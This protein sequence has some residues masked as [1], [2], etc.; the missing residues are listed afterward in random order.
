VHFKF[1]LIKAINVP[2]L[3]KFH[4]TMKL[5]IKV[6]THG[7]LQD[8][9]ALEWCTKNVRQDSLIGKLNIVEEH[10]EGIASCHCI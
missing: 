3:K 8:H 5:N 10:Q 4:N 2:A 6:L 9:L 7:L 1:N